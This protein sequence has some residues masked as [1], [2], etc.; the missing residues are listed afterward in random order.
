MILSIQD[1][2][3]SP[4]EDGWWLIMPKPRTQH[5]RHAPKIPLN[6]VAR[7]ALI[8]D[9]LNIPQGLIFARWKNASSLK[10]L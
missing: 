9:G 3:C 10:H 7:G 1:S 5:K 6:H 8:P 2:W 4:Q